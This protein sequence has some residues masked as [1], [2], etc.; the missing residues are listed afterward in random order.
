MP[1]RRARRRLL[2]TPR[3]RF[4]RLG[5]ACALAPGSPTRIGGGPRRQV[6]TRALVKAMGSRLIVGSAHHTNTN[7][8]VER[9]NGVISDTLA[10][11]R[12]LLVAAQPGLLLA[13]A[14]AGGQGPQW[15]VSPAHRPGTSGPTPTSP[16]SCSLWTVPTRRSGISAITTKHSSR[17]PSGRWSR[18]SLVGWL[19]RNTLPDGRRPATSTTSTSLPLPASTA[20]RLER[21]RFEY[22]ETQADEAAPA[23][24][25]PA[26]GSPP[27][28]AGNYAADRAGFGAITLHHQG[29][30]LPRL[31]PG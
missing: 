12:E 1:S 27:V 10:T 13:R 30:V 14:R 19:A 29:W 28:L 8:Q 7:A 18:P 23:S 21:R 24:A 22:I 31:G 2:R 3:R 26:P 11:V 4:A 15:A 16:G 17:P 6:E 20:E 9:A 25:L 5:C